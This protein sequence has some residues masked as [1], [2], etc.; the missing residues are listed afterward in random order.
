MRAVR[1]KSKW[2]AG[3]ALAG[4]LLLVAQDWQTVTNL[5]GVDFTGLTPAKKQTA[6]HALRAQGCSCGCDMKVA[7]CRVKDPGCT[8]SRG[9]ASVIVDSIKQGRSETAAL[10]DAKASK[11]G[12]RPEPKLLDDPV[13]IPTLGSPFMGPADARITLVEFSDFQCPYCSKA[14]AQINAILK[15]YPN[16]VK[17][18]FKQYPLDNHPAAAICAAAALAAHN[19]GKFWQLHDLMFANRSKLGRPAILAWAAQIGL[20]MK[21]FTQDLDSDP[22]KKAVLRDSADGDKAGVEGTPTIFINGQRYNGEY[23]L[24]TIRPILDGELKRLAAKK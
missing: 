14:V 20:D 9:L 6:L 7:E 22:I 24:D 19:Q 10:A 8:Y 21:R 15:A 1:S 18:I 17:L 5:A 3:L 13:L 4:A 16:D 11:F 2:I 23:D 12:H